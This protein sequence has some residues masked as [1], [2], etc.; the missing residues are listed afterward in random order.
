MISS[1]SY[2]ALGILARGF[3]RAGD[4]IEPLPVGILSL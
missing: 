1:V 2:A 3:Y 4:I